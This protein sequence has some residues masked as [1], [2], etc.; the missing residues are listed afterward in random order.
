MRL[1][2]DDR[3]D[4][5]LASFHLSLTVPCGYRLSSGSATL[6]TARSHGPLRALAARSTKD[7]VGVPPLKAAAAVC[8]SFSD[9]CRVIYFLSSCSEC[10]RRKQKVRRSLVPRHRCGSGRYI[11][12]RRRAFPGGPLESDD[13]LPNADDPFPPVQSGPAMQQLQAPV[14]R[15]HLRIQPHCVSVALLC[16]SS[17]I[18]PPEVAVIARP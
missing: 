17:R 12:L 1:I 7:I 2:R 16:D 14:P 6:R 9:T 4:S 5:G 11:D 15:A 13:R 10:R 18:V 8:Y 3:H